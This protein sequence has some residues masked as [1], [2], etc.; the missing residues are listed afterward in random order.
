MAQKR[1]ELS[2][3]GLG[4]RPGGKLTP[5]QRGAENGPAERCHCRLQLPSLA[6]G[7]D[8]LQPRAQDFRQ[9]LLDRGDDQRLQ[10]LGRPAVIVHIRQRVHRSEHQH[11]EVGR[12]VVRVARKLPLERASKPITTEV[13]E[14]VVFINEV[15]VERRAVDR[16]TSRD[17]LNRDRVEALFAEQLDE[18]FLQQSTRALDARVADGLE[19]IRRARQPRLAPFALRLSVRR[20]RLRSGS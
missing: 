8:W 19:A 20:L 16:R 15:H 12:A 5:S 4:R 6:V 2:G 11:A 17:L 13:R 18:R 1:R 7:H 10:C 3:G 14:E 9:F